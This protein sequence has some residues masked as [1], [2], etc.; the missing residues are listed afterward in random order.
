MGSAAL[1]S[2]RILDFSKSKL[3]EE[4]AVRNQEKVGIRREAEEYKSQNNIGSVAGE[5]SAQAESL[6]HDAAEEAS[7]NVE[8][9]VSDGD[10]YQF[11]WD[12][13]KKC[14][15]QDTRNVIEERLRHNFDRYN[16]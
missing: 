10:I 16:V 12:E 6:I 13:S 2:F 3:T 9:D 11:Y 5:Q 7:K 4:A 8:F 1:F 15:T 14:E